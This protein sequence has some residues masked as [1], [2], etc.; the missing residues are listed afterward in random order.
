MNLRFE[1]SKNMYEMVDPEHFVVLAGIKWK[2]H[3]ITNVVS[4][5]QGLNLAL[6]QC[7]WSL[8]HE[9]IKCLVIL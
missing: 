1:I 7:R 2:S 5:T 8:P 9:I 3:A 4:N 6:C